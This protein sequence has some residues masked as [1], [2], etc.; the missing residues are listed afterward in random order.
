MQEQGDEGCQGAPLDEGLVS[1]HNNSAKQVSVRVSARV[2]RVRVSKPVGIATNCSNLCEMRS[3]DASETQQYAS[4]ALVSKC[5]VR[6][7]WQIA[8]QRLCGTCVV[9]L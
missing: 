6:A 7:Q 1:C 2:S 4:K 9:R 5:R 3:S 8:L